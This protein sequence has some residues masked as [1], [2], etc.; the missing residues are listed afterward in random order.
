M[1]VDIWINMCRWFFVGTLVSWGGFVRSSCVPFGLGSSDVVQRIGYA[2]IQFDSSRHIQPAT[3]HCT[4][5][6]LYLTNPGIWF[7]IF[8]FALFLSINNAFIIV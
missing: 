1:S 5:T 6:D 8:H 4:A 3:W 7:D 2:K